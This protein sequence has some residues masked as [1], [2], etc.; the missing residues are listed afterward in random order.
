MD[1]TGTFEMAEALAKHKMLVAV[2]KHYTVDEWKAWIASEGGK[3]ALP[4]VS[5]S[6]GSGEA[7]L[8][9]LGEVPALRRS[10][11]L[12]ALCAMVSGLY[13]ML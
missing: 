13:S 11:M 6:A 10:C 5:V 1:T 8:A 7:D 12:H 2:H 9:K 4:Y 3:A